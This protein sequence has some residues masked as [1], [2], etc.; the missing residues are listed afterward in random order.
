LNERER[1]KASLRYER[2]IVKIGTWLRLPER[3]KITKV[4]HF[5]SPEEMEERLNNEALS[6]SAKSV[7]AAPGALG[8]S[9]W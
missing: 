4:F 6:V 5:E 1:I 8:R 7:K 9:D 2:R 3:P